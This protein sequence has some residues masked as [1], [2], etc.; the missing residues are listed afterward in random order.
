MEKENRRGLREGE[1]ALLEIA[2]LG[3]TEMDV[4][5]LISGGKDSALALYYAL[6]QEYDVKYLVTKIPS[7]ED[8]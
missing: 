6:K 7:R 1:E 3:M 2:F 5:A 4:A 8:S